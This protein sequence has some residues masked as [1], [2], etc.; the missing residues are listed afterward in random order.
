MQRSNWLFSYEASSLMAASSKKIEHH[1]K[2][3]EFWEGAKKKVM[4]EVKE[5]GIEVS[6]S[7]SDQYIN[8]MSSHNS[9]QVMVRNDLQVK[10]TECHEKMRDHIRQMKEYIGWKQVFDANPKAMLQLNADDYLV[11]YG[12]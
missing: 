8:K 5:S 10:L 7:I 4:D 9:P 2:R 1:R 12:E 11:F 6:E 3:L